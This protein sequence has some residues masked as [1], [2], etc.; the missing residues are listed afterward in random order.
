MKNIS[1]IEKNPSIRHADL[2]ASLCEPLSTLGIKFFGYTAVDD[3]GNTYCLG[4]KADYAT[5]YLQQNHAQ[6][7]IHQ[8]NKKSKKDLQYVF[9][10]YCEL[11]ENAKSLYKMAAEF[12]QGHT[13][14]ITKHDKSMTHCFHF[15]GDLYDEAINQR[16]LNH[17]D[18]LHLFMDCFNNDLTRIPELKSLFEDP[19]II[20]NSHW[21]KSE[22]T[23]INIDPRSVNLTR[24]AHKPIVFENFMRY[25]LSEKERECLRW[26][27][28][29]KSYNIIAEIMGI[30]SKTI[31]R[32]VTSIKE[33]YHCYTLFQLGEKVNNNF[34]SAFLNKSLIAE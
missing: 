11:S 10:D 7:D 23:N 27:H 15:S 2:I 3:I 8:R 20:D 30:S 25:L 22:I 33:K 18:A 5:A 16:Y 17:L 6:N 24:E 19:L 14:T 13:L 31:E 28:A 34:L 4:S 1:E 12:N 26:M 32:Y 9:W 29:G 21:K